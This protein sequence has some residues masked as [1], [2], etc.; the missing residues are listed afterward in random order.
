MA[1]NKNLT[2]KFYENVNLACSLESTESCVM[3]SE[4]CFQLQNGTIKTTVGVK[5][6]K[7][8]VLITGVRD[9]K[10]NIKILKLSPVST[11]IIVN[12]S[13]EQ[14]EILG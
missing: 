9:W 11:L 7:L 1:L 3:V 2:L 5:F 13:N 10:K 6:N 8:I 4:Q 12:E 14:L